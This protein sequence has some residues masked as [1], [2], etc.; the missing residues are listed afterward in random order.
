MALIVEGRESRRVTFTIEVEAAVLRAVIGG[1]KIERVRFADG[2][3]RKASLLVQRLKAL[4]VTVDLDSTK[5]GGPG[6]HTPVY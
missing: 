2:K 1:E 4:G 3:W 6:D 5:I